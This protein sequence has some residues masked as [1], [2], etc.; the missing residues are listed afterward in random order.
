MT[1]KFIL[2]FY[3]FAVAASTMFVTHF[4]YASN[5]REENAV[6]SFSQLFDVRS[7]NATIGH[8][9][10]QSD[11]TGVPS[12]LFAIA[13]KFHIQ[14]KSEH[15]IYENLVERGCP[16][17]IHL[18]NPSEWVTVA[19]FGPQYSSVYDRGA[20]SIV[21]NRS[22]KRRYTQEALIYSL[23]LKPSIKFTD[24]VPVLKVVSGKGVV[25]REV[26]FKNIGIKTV[27]L[28]VESTSCGCT[29]AQISKS[30]LSPSE[31]GTLTIKMQMGAWGN[32]TEQVVLR[33]SDPQ[34]PRVV[35]GFQVQVPY[36]VFPSPSSLTMESF[37]GK[38]KKVAFLVAMPMSARIAK[39]AVSRPFLKVTVG[40]TQRIDGGQT[41]RILVELL[42]DAP[43]GTFNDEV[44]VDLQ[45]TTVPH[46]V[47]PIEG[48]IESNVEVS[49]RRLFLGQ[50]VQGTKIHKVLIVR[51]K[52]GKTFGL[53]KI[54]SGSSSIS[55][56]ANQTIT[57]D[58]HAVEVEIDVTSVSGT[59]IDSN[60]N[61]V[62]SDDRSLSIPVVGMVVNKE[63]SA[64]E[65]VVSVPKLGDLAPHFKC[66]DMIG[67]IIDTSNFI[68][69]K[70]LLLTFFPKCFTGGCSGQL[71]SLQEKRLSIS[72]EGT[73]I[74]AISTDG[75]KDQ[76]AFATKLGL[77]FPLVPDVDRK[78]SMLFG[79][80]EQPT[81]L[82]RR[83][84]VLIDK[85]GVV[86]WVDTDVHVLT[87][88]TD[89][90]AKLK[91]LGLDR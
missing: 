26:K 60:I 55:L 19:A 47:V 36:T 16:A 61:I 77:S 20:V 91:E 15:I 44:I 1:K 33:T 39:V 64:H 40:D 12:N 49:P 35:I 21:S 4:A 57:S 69:K 42:Q 53:K 51:D 87:H 86:R 6:L 89:V 85:Q 45:G 3:M 9:N 25:E 90:L 81:D 76:V 43:E 67:N 75:P 31:T 34:W 72:N 28:E 29:S 5:S 13:N 27:A 79:A 32:K 41:Q 22:L 10:S 54:E 18:N 30:S 52:T 59:L 7:Q 82:D 14:L 23:G 50:V 58:A 74:V 73:E 62:L 71:S 80:T 84:S 46:I 38:S 11:S 24:P 70:N 37:Q 78:I 83:M 8:S 88:G 68:G 48:N 65:S 63:S 17:I 2:A 56:K 66:S